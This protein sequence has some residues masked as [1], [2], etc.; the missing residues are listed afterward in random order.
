MLKENQYL[1]L[2]GAKALVNGMMGQVRD[3]AVTF[4]SGASTGAAPLTIVL[5]P[6]TRAVHVNIFASGVSVSNGDDYDV[7]VSSGDSRENIVQLQF[8]KGGSH[9]GGIS[10]DCT[11]CGDNLHFAASGAIEQNGDMTIVSGGANVPAP[12]EGAKELTIHT[13]SGASGNAVDVFY[14]AINCGA[15]GADGGFYPE[16]DIA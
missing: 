9:S 1:D 2:N 3:K 10:I 16:S 11:R 5:H 14:Y 4:S 7:Y 6:F 13:P 8:S 12:T 15:P